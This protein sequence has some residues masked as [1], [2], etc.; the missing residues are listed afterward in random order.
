MLA[1]RP[2]LF[3]ELGGFTAELFLYHEDLEL[4]WRARMRGLRIVLEPAADVLHDYEYGR[5]LREE[6]LHGAEPARL[7]RSAYSLRL[8]L[9]LAP[10]L[11]AAE[12]GLV[13][14]AWREGWLRDKL[15]GWGWCARNTRWVLRHRR[16]LQRARTRVRP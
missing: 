8:L 10:V 1:I 2:A 9:L 14:V 15:A 12:A 3:E 5:N 6:L 16:D 11:L 4:G 7:R 13:F